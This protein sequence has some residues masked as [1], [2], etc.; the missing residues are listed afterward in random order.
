MIKLVLTLL[1]LKISYL[2]NANPVTLDEGW[3]KGVMKLAMLTLS[4]R[5]SNQSVSE[6]LLRTA[7]EQEGEKFESM[8][9][10][11]ARP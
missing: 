10:N 4:K 3:R 5:E 8:H 6:N 9:I 11:T 1:R 7:G 2:T